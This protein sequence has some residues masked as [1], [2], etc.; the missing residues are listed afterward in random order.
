MLQIVTERP[1]LQNRHHD[2]AEHR[3]QLKVVVDRALLMPQH[4]ESGPLANSRLT[5]PV[6]RAREVQAAVMPMLYGRQLVVG[7]AS[8]RVAH[9]EV[10]FL[11]PGFVPCRLALYGRALCGLAPADPLH[12]LAFL[13]DLGRR[14][15]QRDD[16]GEDES[17]TAQ[18]E[19]ERQQERRRAGGIRGV[20]DQPRGG[21]RLH[22]GHAGVVHAVDRHARDQG[23]DERGPDAVEPQR[24]PQRRRPGDHRDD[25]GRGDESRVVAQRG[26]HPYGA[27]AEVVHAGHAEPEDR[28]AEHQRAVA[29]A[30]AE[31][32]DEH[33][34][35]DHD[36]RDH[37]GQDGEGHVV[38]DG[39]AG[40]G[41]PE[42]GDEVHHPDPGG[43][44]GQGRQ[45]QPASPGRALVSA[46][47][48]GAPKPEKAAHARNHVGHGRVQAAVSEVVDVNHEQAAPQGP[49][50]T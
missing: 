20:H 15:R 10:Q 41:E 32:D 18:A 8:G 23:R 40:D 17:D 5:H 42:H 29:R 48:G 4:R 50:G 21:L 1:T 25:H 43:P 28:A 3:A 46:R 33:A 11:S 19:D 44:D 39:L 38:A 26:L 9:V 2:H 27:H 45:G 12:Q 6:H 24:H 30:A 34:D 35:P 14:R 22:R 36:H 16:R 49:R 13:D 37:H 31:P 47:P 7:V